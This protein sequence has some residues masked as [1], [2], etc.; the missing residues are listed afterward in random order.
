MRAF[1]IR[2]AV[3]ACASLLVISFIVFSMVRMIPGDPAEAMLGK[4]ATREAVETLRHK[5]GLDRPLFT[6]YFSWLGDLLQGDFGTSL[7]LDQPVFDRVIE[8][9]PRTLSIVLYATIVSVAIALVAGIISATH[10][11]TWIDFF[12]TSVSLLGI[13]LPVF[14]T[15]VLFMLVFSVG[16]G[17]L[18]TSGYAAPSDGFLEYLKHLIMPGT[19]LAIVV[20]GITTRMI[21]SSLLEVLHQTYITAARAKGLKERIVLLKHAL[22]NALIPVITL[23]GVTMGYMLGGSVLIEE[24]FV[25]PGMGQVI[26]DS[27]FRRDYPMIQAAVL[28]YAFTFASVN[29]LT[30][31]SYAFLDPRI[32]YEN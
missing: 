7:R 4:M 13:S 25:Y 32:R 17:V 29:L 20:T 14:Y 22:R 6:Q 8:R 2:R 30:D 15:G 11:N 24:V 5:M 19:A 12:V 10:H 23:F 1:L 18:P 21:R 31:I 26:V 28:A 9:Y 3:G 16:L 27:I